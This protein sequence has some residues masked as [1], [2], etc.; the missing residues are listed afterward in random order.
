MPDWNIT[1]VKADLALDQLPRRADGS[2]SWGTV[3][4]AHLDTGYR[5]IDA[6]GFAPDGSSP[7]VLTDLGGDFLKPRRGTAEDPLID[8]GFMPPGHGTRSGS[9]I[10]ADG[11][12]FTGIAPGLPLVPMRVT[13]SSLVTEEVARAIGKAL[14]RIAKDD[15]PQI[16]AAVANISLGFPIVC[17][18]AMGRGVDKA[19]MAGIIVVAATGQ[20]I[21][22]VTYPGKHRR[23]IGVAG[24]KRLRSGK[25][26]PY[27]T[28]NRYARV[29]VWAPADPIRR[30]NVVAEPPSRQLGDGTT[31]ATVHV[32]AAACMWLRKH[33]S[34][35]TNA[36]GRTWKRVEAFRRLLKTA[37]RPLPFKPIRG[38]VAQGLD[39]NAL[40]NAPLPDP[41]SLVMEEDLAEDDVA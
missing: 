21:D 6:F 32:T 27:Y 23:T 16:R 10:S 3:R 41:D 34:A 26:R 40:L 20:E 36:Y 24:I 11:G 29:D 1:H 5:K 4:F 35:I 7:I 17:D 8:P 37:G 33:G 28:Y 25:F 9:A 31:Y 18:Q 12:G 15:P 39:I 19:Y 14:T 2:V 13:T 38:N 22:R 30:A